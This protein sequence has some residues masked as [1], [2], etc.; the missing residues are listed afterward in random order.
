MVAHS[1]SFGPNRRHVGAGTRLGP[2]LGPDVFAGGHARQESRFLLFAAVLHQGRAEQED[3]VL[4]DPCR[5]PGTVVFLF[6]NQPLDQVATTAAEFGRPGDHAPTAF[7]ELGFPSAVLGKTLLGVERLQRFTRYIGRQPGPRIK[8]K[9]LLG[10]GIGQV[11]GYA[12]S[13]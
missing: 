10:R 3:A 1:F 9:G 8:A 2:G 5:R 4:V 11:H 12:F 7:I 6:E 13:R